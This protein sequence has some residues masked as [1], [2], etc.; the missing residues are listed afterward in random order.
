MKIKSISILF[1]CI[2]FLLNGCFKEEVQL[3]SQQNSKD[4]REI[5]EEIADLD[6]KIALLLNEFK[7]LKSSL[8]IYESKLDSLRAAYEKKESDRVEQEKA[9]KNVL[10]EVDKYTEM[11]QRQ[12]ED[13]ELFME[14]ME[15]S[16][17]RNEEEHEKNMQEYR[18][19]VERVKGSL[20]Q[21]REATITRREVISQEEM[22]EEEDTSE[23][24][25]EGTVRR[26]K[27][28]GLGDD[29]KTY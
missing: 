24:N 4:I 1:V 21:K 16:L 14:K 17:A 13:Y 12:I 5:K 8:D 3:P 27:I 26:G 6:V 2:L 22:T 19:I 20:Q 10:N 28:K 18:N 11:T 7:D 29:Y 9:Y 15:E 25:I 23:T